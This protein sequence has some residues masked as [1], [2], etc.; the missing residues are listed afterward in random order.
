MKILT[1][2]PTDFTIDEKMIIYGIPRENSVK[3]NKILVE[4]VKEVDPSL[5][6]F[7]F[8]ENYH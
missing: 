1:P 2:I 3:V 7:D 5:L 6:S 8:D 4:N